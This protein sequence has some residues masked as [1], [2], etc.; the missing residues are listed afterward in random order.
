MKRLNYLDLDYSP[1]SKEVVCEY[2]VEPNGIPLKK[3][4]EE[5]AAESSIGTW[6]DI[7]TM[8]EQIA[9]KLK[10]TVFSIRKNH[11][12]IAYPEDLFEAGN[13]PEILSSIAGNIFGMKA[14]KNLRLEDISFPKSLPLQRQGR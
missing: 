6:T 9:K 8:N 5:I 12:Q 13:M 14:L 10:P 11:V 2:F 1:G 4:A 7:V 3:A